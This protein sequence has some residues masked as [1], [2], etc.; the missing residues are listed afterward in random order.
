LQE[1]YDVTLEAQKATIAA[2]KDGVAVSQIDKIAR[3]IITDAGYGDQYTHSTGHGVGLDI[4]EGPILSVNAP[5]EDQI[6]AG[7]IL[8]IEPGIYVTNIGG[9]RIEDDVVVTADGFENLTERIT[10]DLIVIDK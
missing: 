10:T 4:H 1:I 6:K 9:V 3:D 7:M 8:T 2:V 5:A